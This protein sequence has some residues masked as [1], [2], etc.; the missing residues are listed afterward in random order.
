M[1]T[2]LV[3]A[4]FA[5]TVFDLSADALERLQAAGAKVAAT[6]ADAAV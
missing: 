5:V 4:G 2:N 6:A 3:N 1:A